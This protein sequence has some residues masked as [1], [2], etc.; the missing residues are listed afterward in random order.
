M[1]RKTAN[2]IETNKHKVIEAPGYKNAQL[3]AFNKEAKRQGLEY[4]Y[5]GFKDL[6]NPY[7]DIELQ[8]RKAIYKADITFDY[9]VYENWVLMGRNI[10]VI[11]GDVLKAMGIA[12]NLDLKK[13]ED[14]FDVGG[15]L[16]FKPLDNEIVERFCKLMEVTNNV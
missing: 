8:F 9:D 1:I 5:A 13:N 7:G 2:L 10:K 12:A 3:D 11:N 15:V 6:S 4:F 14:Y 16:G